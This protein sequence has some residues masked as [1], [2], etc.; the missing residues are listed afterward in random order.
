MNTVLWIVQIILGI[1]LITVTFTH[2]FRKSKPTMQDAMQKMGTVSRRL[3]TIIAVCTFIGTIG[4][5]L[6]GILGLPAWIVPVTAVVMSIMLL[7]SIFFH[8][9]FREKPQV[10][11]SVILFAFAAFIAY[12][13]WVLVPS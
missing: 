5:I 13:R 4:L 6:P 11:V 9:K 8:V 7:A 1:K 3:L 10:F 2:G 12:G